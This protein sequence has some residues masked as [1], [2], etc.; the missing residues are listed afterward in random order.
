[1]REYVNEYVGTDNK[2]TIEAEDIAGNVGIGE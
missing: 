1:M 2:L